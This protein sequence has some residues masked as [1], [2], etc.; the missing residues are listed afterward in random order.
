[1]KYTWLVEKYLEGELKGEALRKFELEILRKPEV[2]KE[3]EKIRSMNNFM[4]VQHQKMQG[5]MGLIEDYNDIDNTL[6]EEEI[7]RELEGLMIRK[8]SSAR[9]D[10]DEF[11]TKVTESRIRQTL[12]ARKSKTMLVKRISIWMAASSLAILL[13]VSAYLL[14]DNNTDHTR[15]YNR[16]YSP[17]QADAE[18]SFE[19]MDDPFSTAL[20]A[21]SKE[22]YLKAFLIMNSIPEDEVSNTYYLYKGI[23][24]MELGEYTIAIELFGKLDQDINLKHEGLWYKS[25]CFLGMGDNKAAREALNEIIQ[26]DGY[27]KDMASNLLRKI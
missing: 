2:A 25:L 1:M 8:I 16:Y 21:Y 20:R 5:G 19:G 15:L 23:T 27:Y 14:L 7:G 18:R 24:A 13:A 3:V 22:E 26:M 10:I 9:G 17:R 4:R 6:S 11:E 12:S